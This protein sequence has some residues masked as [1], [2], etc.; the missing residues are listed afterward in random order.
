MVAQAPFRVLRRWLW[1]ATAWLCAALSSLARVVCHH[2]RPPGFLPMREEAR[3]RV[4]AAVGLEQLSRYLA[5]HAAFD[6]YCRVSDTGRRPH[7]EGEPPGR[8]GNT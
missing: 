8:Q 6:E 2:R 3:L 5:N 4:N 1:T 7:R